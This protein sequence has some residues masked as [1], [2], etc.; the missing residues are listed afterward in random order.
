MELRM[1]DTLYK[2]L[3]NGI[4]FLKNRGYWNSELPKSIT[5]NIK[6]PLREYQKKALENFVFYCEDKQYS[7]IEYKHLLFHMATGSGKTNLIASA[8]LYLYE[9]G[10]RDFIF[11]VNT[12][13]I[14]TK[15]KDNIINKYSSKYLFKDKIII[16]NREV[17]INEITDTF[18]ISKTDDINIMF[19]TTHKLHG[20]LE[21]TIKEN[22]ITYADFEKKKIVLIADEA[23]HLNSELKKTKNKEDEENL[24]SWGMTTKRLL[25]THKENI[26]LEFT[27]TAEI[28]SS[29]EIANHYKNKIIAEYPLKLFREDRYSKEIKLIN[30]NFSNAQRMLQAL[31]VSEYRKI[32]A[33]EH[34]NKVVKP[35]VMFKNPKGIAKVNASFEEFKKLID[36]LK[37][38]DIEEIFTLSSIKAIE[39]LKQY[40]DDVEAFT[41]RLQRA[42]RAENCLVIYSTSADKEEKLK[43]LNSLEEV[44]N[45]IRV[46]F[47]VNVLNEGWDVLNLFDIVKLD[48]AKTG[49]ANTTSEA[50]LIGRGARYFPFEYKD[51]DKYKRKFDR[52]FTNPL[53]YLEEVYFYSINKS[54]YI[55]GLKK[56][57]SKIGLMDKEDEAQEVVLKLKES[58][59]SHDLYKSGV[60][61]VNAKIPQDKSK[62]N[63]ISDY[64]GNSYKSQNISIDNSS[65]ELK[66]FDEDV[67]ESKFLKP[68]TLKMS[69]IDKDV[70]R[71][72]INKKPFFYFSS[73]KRYFKNLKSISEFISD[74]NY[75]GS[76]EFSVRFSK[77]QQIDIAL[78]V[79]LI[80]DILESIEKGVLKNATEFIGSSEFYPVRISDKIPKTKTLKLKESDSSIDIPYDWYIF[81]KHGGTSEERAFTDFILKISDD[82]KHK[83]KDIKLIRNE[84]AFN[85][86]SFDKFRNGAKF[87]PDFL[88]LLKDD[89]CFYQIFCEP[90]GDWAKD[91]LDGFENS[92]EKWKNEFLSAIT[93]FTNEAKIKLEDINKQ[94][95]KLYENSCYKLY[96]LPFYNQAMETEFKE[97][98][99]RILL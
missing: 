13:N 30:D 34:L 62:I 33:K 81:D 42:F 25:K 68:V 67:E 89:K 37:P 6:Q 29:Q 1:S 97:D 15:T 78:Q 69:D 88:L 19:T 32:V 86:H 57:L 77:E 28:N 44:A 87:E 10:Y 61:Y 99:K 65:K 83:Y 72:A 11:F 91:N 5:S 66:I 35:V 70:V 55:S 80:L 56:E 26:L 23:H 27:A 17:N 45:P 9:Q 2:E 85:I 96:G 52:D 63:S 50:Q 49:G 12:T 73:L 24:K 71:V 21:T 76:V 51:E 92:P 54:D 93:K 46:I 60:V 20:D 38:K 48:E 36:T 94:N 59:L 18:D 4:E 7:K 16:N 58:F 79:K 64:M 41:V 40:V 31:M 53:R 90:K 47:A 75:L 43:L 98:F 84:K 3:E 8:I 82:L 74:E 95:L 22:S 39:D 14:I